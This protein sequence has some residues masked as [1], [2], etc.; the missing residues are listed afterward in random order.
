MDNFPVGMHDTK[1]DVEP[2]IQEMDV[3]FFEG[4]SFLFPVA[5]SRPETVFGAVGIAIANDEYVIVEE[6]DSAQKKSYA[7]SRKVFGKLSYQ[8]PL[9]EMKSISP[10]ELVKLK[11]R[12]PLTGKDVKIVKGRMVDPS[13]GTG[14]VMLVPAHDPSHLIMAR[15]GGIDDVIPVISTPDLPEMPGVGIDT[16][17]PAELKD[18]IDSIYRAEYYKGTMR[19]NIIQ[20]VPEFMKQKVKDYIA[21]KRVIDARKD[22]RDLLRVMDRYDRIYE[23]SNG[24]IYCRCGAEIVVK[25]IDDQWFLAYDDPKWK[26]QTLRSLN[27][28]NFFPPEVRKDF[29][30]AVFN[31]KRRAVGRS[32]GIGVKLPW[33]ESQIIDSL[34]DSTIYTA[35]YTFSHIAKGERLIDDALDYILLGKGNPEEIE[36]ESGINTKNIIKMR[37]E[38][39]YWY[40]VDSRHSGRDLVQNHLPFFIY[41]HLAIFGEEM[42]PKQIVLNGFIRVGGKKMSKSLR[43]IYPLEK[44]IRQFGVDPI[45][46]ALSSSAQIIQDTDFDPR[47]VEAVSDQLKKVFGLISKV[48]ELQ[49]NDVEKNDG[50]TLAD[51]WLSTLM[52]RRIAEANEKYSQMEFKDVF[53]LVIYTLYEDIKDYTELGEKL[54]PTLLRKVASAWIRMMCPAVPHMAEELW[55]KGFEGFA[56]LQPFPSEDEFEEYEEAE[57]EVSYLNT[58]IEKV[59]NLES[60]I[61]KEA[62]KIIIYVNSD[63]GLK[64]TVRKAIDSIEQ[65]KGLKDFLFEMKGDE[66]ELEILFKRIEQYDRKLRQL[67]GRYLDVDEMEVLTKNVNYLMRK[68]NVSE[69]SIFDSNDPMSPDIK[70]K[71]RSALPYAPA[72]VIV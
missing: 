29:E 30:K 71:K 46:V 65:G 38:F 42:L 48:L 2:E 51:K 31:M 10:D 15:E 27:L 54:N 22:V 69:I 53:E 6:T 52:R 16:E 7:I 25:K 1:G 47:S 66:G 11:A 18:Y 62:E 3:I 4:E 68:L 21:G 19:D 32:R 44:A 59:R 24:P 67:L 37:N 63:Q 50:N 33:N 56:S 41:N 72:I 8:K 26:N 49:G 9:K 40:P 34:S 70:G 58:L 28:I 57:F 45:R 13:F 20:M 35:F 55:S 43:N 61:S 64:E 39:E 5:T 23:I 12:N 14:L 17:D 36:K 60:T